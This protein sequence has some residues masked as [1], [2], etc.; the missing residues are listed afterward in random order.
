M[1]E[2]RCE[3]VPKEVAVE[4]EVEEQASLLHGH[5]AHGPDVHSGEKWAHDPWFCYNVGVVM[6]DKKAAGDDRFTADLLGGVERK[7]PTVEGFPTPA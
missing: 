7:P 1:L 2:A 5:H 4:G 3:Q 6:R